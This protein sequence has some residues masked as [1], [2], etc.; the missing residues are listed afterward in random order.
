VPHQRRTRGCRLCD[1]RVASVRR[2]GAVVGGRSAIMLKL[3]AP[4]GRGRRSIRL[5][6]KAGGVRFRSRPRRRSPWGTPCRVRASHPADG[7]TLIP[8]R[9]STSCAQCLKPW[10]DS[11]PK[12]RVFASCTSLHLGATS[13]DLRGFS[14][15]RPHRGTCRN[16]ELQMRCGQI[17]GKKTRVFGGLDG[18]FSRPVFA[19][20][21]EHR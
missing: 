4:E 20:I 9:S 2:G 10:R 15:V 5:S 17:A 1:G 11:N 3:A 21:R 14:R 13:A 18:A 16:T 8:M 19:R 6:S 7:A 12:M